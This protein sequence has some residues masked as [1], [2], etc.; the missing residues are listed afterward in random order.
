MNG[1]AFF[2]MNE[3][4]NFCEP[5]SAPPEFQKTRHFIEGKR[6][7]YTFEGKD[8]VTALKNLSFFADKG[9]ILAIIGESGSGKSTLLK[10]IYGL[11]GPQTGEVRCDGYVIPDPSTRLIPGHPDMRMV[12]Q[13][14]DDLNTY[15]SVWDNVASQLSNT[16]LNAK[17]RN[18]KRALKSLRLL[19]LKDQRVYDLSGGEKQRVAIARALVNQP[20]VLL[21]DEPFNQVDAAF[22]ET[23][24]EDIKDIVNRSGLTIILVSHDPSEVLAL[25]D[26]LLIIRKGTKIAQG[27][28]KGLFLRPP[29]PYVASLLAQANLLTAEEA[30][31]VGI[32]TTQKIGFH[33]KSIQIKQNKTG[34][35]RVKDLKFK[36]FHLDV[37]LVSGELT[38]KGILDEGQGLQVGD[39]V[40]IT[41][42]EY[43]EY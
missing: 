6:L 26:Q 23:L 32:K 17:T 3:N 1:F 2:I 42:L 10:L 24:Q 14:F 43:W 34:N 21:L 28:P 20:K 22:R 27:N 4:A 37:V 39:Q 33:R 7:S 5:I 12:S 30:S 13:G 15:A 41:I 11:L 25:A 31:L 29:H 19:H 36:G 9:Q 38:L 40:D 8:P 18:T 16:D 35:F